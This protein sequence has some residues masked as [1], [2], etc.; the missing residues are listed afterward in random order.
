MISQK[1]MLTCE[2]CKNNFLVYNYRKNTARFCSRKCCQKGQF[3]N[4][5]LQ[6]RKEA[7]K[8]KWEDSN[9]RKQMSDVHKGQKAWNKGI[10]FKNITDEETRQKRRLKVGRKMDKHPNWKGGIT[11]E[12]VKIRNNVESRLWRESVFARDN[13]TCQLCCNKGGDLEAHH[14][15]K[16]SDYPGLRFAIDNGITLCISC[17]KKIH[18]R[19]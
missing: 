10:P 9:Y 13:F 19:K 16:F 12:N 6:K 1:V 7:Q 2:V 15:K 17:H 8:K 14:I 3:D 4:N 11:P 18:K 5:W